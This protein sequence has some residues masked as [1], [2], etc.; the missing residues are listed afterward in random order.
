M[1]GTPDVP[2]PAEAF[3]PAVKVSSLQA[4]IATAE[5]ALRRPNQTPEA[6]DAGR[7]ALQK[8]QAALGQ[9]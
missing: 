1:F 6:L 9:L 5:T 7:A 4:K 8:L 2:A 3:S